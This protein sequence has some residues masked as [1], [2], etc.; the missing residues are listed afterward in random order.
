[1]RP[2]TAQSDRTMPGH[3]ADV[4][5]PRFRLTVQTDRVVVLQAHDTRTGEVD[6]KV[7]TEHAIR[8]YQMVGQTAD[9]AR[10]SG[11]DQEPDDNGPVHHRAS[12][13]EPE[14]RIGQPPVHGGPSRA[15]TESASGLSPTGPVF[16]VRV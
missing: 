16:D 12:A 15:L 3:G 7:P 14:R 4:I 1:M 9:D 5:S 8:L 13:P 11:R 2:G 10:P 6:W